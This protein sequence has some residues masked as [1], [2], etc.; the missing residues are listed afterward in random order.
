MVQIRCELKFQVIKFRRVSSDGRWTFPGQTVCGMLSFYGK[1]LACEYQDLH[2]GCLRG[3][4]CG[5]VRSWVVKTMLHLDKLPVSAR[6]AT[7]ADIDTLLHLQ[8]C[9]ADSLMVCALWPLP[10]LLHPLLHMGTIHPPHV[11]S[12]GQQVRSALIYIYIYI[13]C[14]LANR[15][16]TSPCNEKSLRGCWQIAAIG[17][18]ACC[19]TKI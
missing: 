14:F 4:L 2:R 8:S 17:T 11:T 7:A 10:S 16:F 13:Y 5:L 12:G 19:T 15:L 6:T 3:N 1:V 9:V 18:L